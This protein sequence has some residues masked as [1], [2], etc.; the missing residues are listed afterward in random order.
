MFNEAFARLQIKKEAFELINELEIQLKDVFTE[1]EK[2]ETLN[3]AKVLAAFQKNHVAAHYFNPTTGYGY[4]DVG[5]D[6]L[7]KVFADAFGTE[8]AVASPQIISGTHAIFIVLSGL[9]KHGDCMLSIS[10]RPY[11]TL[12]DAIGIGSESLPNS[13][14]E[15]GIFYEQVDL[16]TDGR[17]K[18]DEICAKVE[19][20]KPRIAYIQRSRGYEWRE[21]LLPEDMRSERPRKASSPLP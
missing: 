20:L 7:D 14:R 21:S 18:L 3:Q 19:R 5:R 4:D 2:V 12:V 11:D 6:N 15:R 8:S 1:I 9:L 10:G 13:L 16:S 17:F